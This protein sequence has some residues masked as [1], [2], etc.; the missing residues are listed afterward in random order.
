VGKIR[1]HKAPRYVVLSTMLLP[2]PSDSQIS[3]TLSISINNQLVAMY[4]EPR[5][6][7]FQDRPVRKSALYS[8]VSS[9]TLGLKTGYPEVLC[10]VF[11]RTSEA[12]VGQSCTICPP[13]FMGNVKQIPY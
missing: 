9:S 6:D 10:R 8:E 5:W 12:M 13:N 11:I 2:R 4:N 7:R 1:N 3:S